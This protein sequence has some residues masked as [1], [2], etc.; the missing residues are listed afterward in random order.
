MSNTSEMIAIMEHGM[1][2]ATFS[3]FEDLLRAHSLIVYPRGINLVIRDNLTGY[4]KRLRTIGMHDRYMERL[5]DWGALVH[6]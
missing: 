3:E 6:E 1:S 2:L 4:R 5:R